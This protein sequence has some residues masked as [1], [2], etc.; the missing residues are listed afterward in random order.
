MGEAGKEIS[1]AGKDQARIWFLRGELSMVEY[2]DD[3]LVDYISS[4]WGLVLKQGLFLSSF[5]NYCV[6]YWRMSWKS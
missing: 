1:Y 5:F 4:L 3:D 6:G 2:H